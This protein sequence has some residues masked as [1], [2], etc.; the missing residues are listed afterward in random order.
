MSRNSIYLDVS[1]QTDVVLENHMSLRFFDTH[2]VVQGMENICEL[3][4]CLDPFLSQGGPSHIL[5]IMASKRV[6]LFPNSI[7]EIIPSGCDHKYFIFISG[8][9]LA[10][11]LPPILDMGDKSKENKGNCF[12]IRKIMDRKTPF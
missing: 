2:I 8:P 3:R 6:V 5:V 9:F 4:Y 7:P 12:S 1:I 11:S 10:V